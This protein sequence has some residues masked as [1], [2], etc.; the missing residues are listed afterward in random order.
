MSWEALAW[1]KQRRGLGCQGKM[2]LFLLAEKTGS[3]HSCYPSVARLAEEMEVSER[4]V[5]RLLA[6]FEDLGLIKRTPRNRRTTVYTLIIDQ[7]TVT[8]A[9]NVVTEAQ[10]EMG[11]SESPMGD[12]GPAKGDRNAVKGDSQSVTPRVTAKVSPEHQKNTT[13]NNYSVEL[14]LSDD[15]GMYLVQAEEVEITARVCT[16]AWVDEIRRNDVEPSKAQI[17]RVARTCKELLDK[18]DGVRVL[19]AA[20]A[21]GAAGHAA[22]DSSMTIAAGKGF[23]PIKKARPPRVDVKTGMQLDW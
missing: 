3:T 18:N 23:A 21:A 9:D 11:D 20:K 5:Q 6:K 12:N 4:T 22:I 19:E 2:L 7:I 17:G 15:S 8:P 1:A 14:A 16:A 10:V 13:K